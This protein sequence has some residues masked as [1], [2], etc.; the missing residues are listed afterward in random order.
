[1]EEAAVFLSVGF[2]FT[3]PLCGDNKCVLFVC[4]C[5]LMLFFIII[6]FWM[7]AKTLVTEEI[8]QKR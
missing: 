8:V 2:F 1:M 3:G 7:T 6:V 4:K 5:L